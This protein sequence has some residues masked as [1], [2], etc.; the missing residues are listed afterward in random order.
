MTP[1]DFYRVILVPA[2]DFAR[3]IHAPLDTPEARVAM[4]AT[5]GYESNWT[6]RA[7]QPSRIALGFWMNQENAVR[8]LQQSPFGRDL[9]N[10]CRALAIP[11]PGPA[12]IHAA[13]EWND[14]IAYFIARGLAWCD[15]HPLAAIGDEEGA[16]QGYLRAQNPDVRNRARWSRVYQAAASVNEGKP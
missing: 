9:G 1:E 15:P 3:S 5:A 10:A 7:Q 12:L 11:F 6:D 14:A 4:M 13:S 2:A 16:W 8:L